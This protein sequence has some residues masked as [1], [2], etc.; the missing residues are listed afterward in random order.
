M[1][2]QNSSEAVPGVTELDFII[3][4]KKNKHVSF[5]LPDGETIIEQGAEQITRWL[6]QQL[7][8][9]VQQ[10]FGAGVVYTIFDSKGKSMVAVD[11][12]ASAIFK[13]HQQ[14]AVTVQRYGQ[15]S[16]EGVLQL[17]LKLSGEN[18]A[19]EEG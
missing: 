2:E 7:Q 15:L 14:G 3:A 11:I 6:K 17:R 4:N 19:G 9:H 8:Q 12:L 16:A 10:E 13:N 1:P 18:A 5:H